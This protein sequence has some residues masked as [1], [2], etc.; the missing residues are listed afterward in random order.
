MGRKHPDG[1]MST[2][3]QQPGNRETGPTPPA[4]FCADGLR[5]RAA[6]R[7][8]EAAQC[9]QQALTIDPNYADAMHLMGLLSFDG[10]QYDHAVEWL[11]RAIRQAP[12][13]EYLK[14]LGAVLQHVKRHEE[15]L[16][17]FDKAI[18]FQPDSAELWC[19]LGGV[20]LQLGRDHESLLSYQHA[21]KLQPDNFDAASKSGVLLH[22]QERWEEALAHFN[23]C[24]ALQPDRA[25]FLNLR[26]I[27]HRGLRN[28]D[29]Y[30]SDSLRAHALD[31]TD[32]ESCNNVGEALL[33]LGREEDA[34]AW[35]DK[36]L[37]LLPDNP[38]IL[39]NKAEAMSQLRRLDEAAAIYSHVRI[40]APGHVKAEWN[41]ALLKL[42]TGDFAA[43]WAG[44]QARWKIPSF[45][46]RYPKFQQPMWRGEEA[47][48]KTIL[49]H[50]DEGL[51]DTIQFA[52]YVP[53][54]AAR[55]ARVILVVAD[56]LQ[57]LLSGLAGV[58]QCLP[59]SANELPDFDLHCPFS[60]LPMIFGTTLDCIPAAASYLPEPAAE[61]VQAWEK[62]L[63]PRGKVRIGLV[64]SGSS[65]HAND[66]RRSNPFKTLA[67][68]LDVDA[69]FVS[70]QKDL[71]PGDKAA[72]AERGEII[73]LTEQLTDFAEAAA[74]VSCL[75]LVV[76][77][78][79]SVA[80]LAGAMGRPAWIMLP[81]VPD[82]RWL[83]DRD[84]SPWYPAVRLFRQDATRDYA[85]VVDHIRAELVVFARK[86]ESAM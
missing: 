35:F 74:L 36:A 57:P 4:A 10:G 15:A 5:L 50:V 64:W 43:G 66:Q 54:I 49:V 56:A 9:C 84:D 8:L 77:A 53:M 32:A 24:L 69:T 70:L 31:P 20:L 44:R 68:V 86:S 61:R 76:T 65:S 85:K 21:L 73:D 52:R 29:G 51:G 41:L 80:H 45:S 19:C 28:Y 82:Y 25:P 11:S 12:K 1:Q 7:P 71:R 47:A 46:A 75:D 72:L 81:Y 58:A 2:Y 3:E 27:A 6:G 79:T 30:L 13:P 16:K 17:A 59:L 63:G 42:L 26:A 60:S 34:I 14:H 55:G 18:Q 78:D 22:R 33:W 23:M 37:A 62:R 67:R 83:L 39:T 38:I 40:I 48:G